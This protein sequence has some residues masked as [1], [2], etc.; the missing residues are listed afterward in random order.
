MATIKGIAGNQPITIVFEQTSVTR[1]VALAG[2]ADG[3]Q[4][5]DPDSLFNDIEF[6]PLA[7]PGLA[8]GTPAVIFF[9]TRHTGLPSFAVTLNNADVINYTFTNADPPERT[10]HHIILPDL[11]PDYP[12]LMAQ[13]ND[14]EFSIEFQ[15]GHTGTIIFGDIVIFY[16][17]NE[18][19]IST[20]VAMPPIE[21][22]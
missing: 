8:P 1:H 2:T 15:E 9:R 16:T 18:L 22:P 10:W 14:L 7:F 6:Y 4:L 13:G 3:I 20:P 5:P 21:Q 19:T 12:T 11:L 17:S